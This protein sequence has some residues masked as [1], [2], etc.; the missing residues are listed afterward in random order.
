MQYISISLFEITAYLSRAKK[1]SARKNPSSGNRIFCM[2]RA[3][4]NLWRSVI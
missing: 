3:F 2:P 4:F 1:L